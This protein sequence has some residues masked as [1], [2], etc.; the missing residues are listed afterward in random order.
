MPARY[1]QDSI[2]RVRD[3]VDIVDLVST[4]AEL[5]KM[6]SQF[7]GLCP[8]HDERSASFSVNPVKKVYLCHACGA[9]GDAITFVREL[10][11]LDFP[12]TVELLA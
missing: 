5:R 2:D 4:K 11:A 8:F 7:M 12:E 10:E 6:G 9:K 1:T 3:A